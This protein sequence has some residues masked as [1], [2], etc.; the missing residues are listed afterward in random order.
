MTILGTRPEAIKLAPFV[1][2]CQSDT[3]VEHVL[4]STGQHREML[5]QVL[6]VFSLHPDLDLGL[7]RPGQDLGRLTSDALLGVQDAVRRFKPDWL[8][9]QGDT[10]TAFAGALAGFYQG[11]PV[12]HVEAGLRT[13]NLKSP[14]PEELN[15]KLITQIAQLHA[16]P[17]GQ[18]AAN[19]LREA[20][21]PGQVIVTGNTVIDALQWVSRH[22]PGH[23]ALAEALGPRSEEVLSGRR[24]LVLVTGHRREN[25]DG[26]LAAMC[27][28]LRTLAAR[29]DV[30]IVFP[31]HL[32]PLVRRT[33]N[34]SLR[35]Q[36]SVHLLEPLDYVRF[37]GLLRHA[38]LV[39]TDS[40]GIQEEAP[41]LGKP[42]LVTRDTTER[43]EAIEAGTAVLVGTSAKTLVENAT[44][45][46]DDRAAHA[47]MASARNPFGDGQAA[48][49]ILEALLQRHRAA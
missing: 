23:D 36:P 45:L 5:D 24:R 43:P 39:V 18:A 46:L 20:V 21:P 25:L 12:A 30:E 19:L 37:V 44:R 48:P 32:N 8:V 29:G 34:E 26:P 38:Y 47:A 16:A 13:G 28:G 15:R 17:T 41:G 9:V 3:R 14:W 1:L 7:M 11:V 40:G 6:Q 33:V 4:C 42:V 22:H 27:E 31:V 2:A 49:R 35:D 10:T